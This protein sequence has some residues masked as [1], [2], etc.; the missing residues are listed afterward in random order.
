MWGSRFQ[1]Y[2]LVWGSLHSPK[3]TGPYSMSSPWR[4][5]CIPHLSNAYQASPY[6]F[7]SCKGNIDGAEEGHQSITLIKALLKPTLT[8]AQAKRLDALGIQ[9]KVLLNLYLETSTREVFHTILKERGINSK[10]LRRKLEK[11][12]TQL[13]VSCTPAV[14]YSCVPSSKEATKLQ[15]LL[16]AYY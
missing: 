14:S 3:H 2:L 9:L 5:Y 7:H 13:T 6:D 8:S 4:E 15:K 16:Y 11:V 10:P 1:L 12:L